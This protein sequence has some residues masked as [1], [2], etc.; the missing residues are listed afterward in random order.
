[1]SSSNSAQTSPLYDG[2]LG[3]GKEKES[4]PELPPLS[5]E[6][7]TWFSLET[8]GPSTYATTY[9]PPHT[10]DCLPEA[11]SFAASSFVATLPCTAPNASTQDLTRRPSRCRSL[12]SLS[13]QSHTSS[14]NSTKLKLK[15]ALPR[16]PSNLTR[17]L[18]FGKRDDPDDLSP[19]ITV[20][21]EP[22]AWYTVPNPISLQSHAITAIGTNRSSSP[23][24]TSLLKGKGRS[25]SSPHP[26]SALDFVPA[27]RTDI[28]EPIPIIIRNYFDEILPRELRL[29]ILQSLVELHALEHQLAVRDGRWTMAKASSFKGRWVGRDKGI[30]ELVKLSRVSKSWKALVFDGQ[31]W[32]DLHLHSFPGLPVLP[33][34]QRGGPFVRSLN[35]AGHVHLNPTDLIEVADHVSFRVFKEPLPYTHL[36]HINLQGCTAISTRSLHHLLTRSIYLRKLCVKGLGAVTNTTCDILANY[37]PGLISL[38]MS[39]CSNMDAAGIERWATG[40]VVRN[41]HLQL[42]EL[43]LSGIKNVS[44]LMMSALGRAAPNLEVLDLSYARQLHNSALEAF[45]ACE[46]YGH[47][48]N[49]GVETVIVTSRDLGREVNDSNRYRRRITNLRHLC[50]SF[51]LMLS[52]TACS[53]LSHSVPKLEFLELAGIG[54]VLKDAGLIRLLRNTPYIRRL[55]LEDAAD[56]TDAVLAELTPAVGPEGPQPGFQVGHALQHLILSHAANIT[57]AAVLALI[58]SCCHLTV[59]HLDNTAIKGAV[60]RE[61]VALSRQRKAIN[62]KIVAVDCRGIGEGLVKELSVSTRPRMGWRSYAARKLMFLDARDETADL[63]IGQDE[64]DEHRVVLKTFYSWQTVDAVRLAREKRRKLTSKRGANA[65]SNFGYGDSPSRGGTT[66]WWTPGGRRAGS[67][68]SSSPTMNDMNTDNCRIM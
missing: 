45:V 29:Q 33:I 2:L 47:F 4:P 18:L 10:D 23:S 57:D 49:L 20:D 36:T 63:E 26:F 34:T 38:N 22:C 6:T 9:S 52:D 28:F 39:R 30:R 41:E 3:K 62:S 24:R 43:R 12:S 40:A 37:C 44:H 35:L 27:T 55:D 42:K 48:E 1:M 53:N 46:E 58:R 16:T 56:I 25:N 64:C 66:R 15:F 14:S 60:L 59:L 68:H 8:P 11:S 17:K 5:F 32:A 65:S 19:T 21:V 13:V 67:I 50:L 61:F 54:A 31:M 51:C 7:N